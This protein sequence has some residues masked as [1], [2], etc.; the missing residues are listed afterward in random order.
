MNIA[1]DISLADS[2]SQNYSWTTF[3]IGLA[4]KLLMRRYG[5]SLQQR[6][7]LSRMQSKELRAS[8]ES[9]PNL[10]CERL[11]GHAAPNGHCVLENCVRPYSLD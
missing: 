1:A 11:L 6:M 5:N 7:M 9:F 2:F 10:H 3:W 4:V 8:L